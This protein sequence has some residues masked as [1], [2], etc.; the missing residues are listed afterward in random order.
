MYDDIVDNLKMAFPNGK[1]PVISEDTNFWMVRSKGSA[2][3]REF[4]TKKFIA[5]GWN[6]INSTTDLKNDMLPM[7]LKEYHPFG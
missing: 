2:F 1:V 3:Y 7:Y 5:I 6:Y 4:I